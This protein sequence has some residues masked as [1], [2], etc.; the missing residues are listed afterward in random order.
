MNDIIIITETIMNDHDTT[1]VG[2]SED[3][4][5]TDAGALAEPETT[6]V[7]DSETA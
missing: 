7:P 5:N 2:V 6:G 1:R 4:T 3:N